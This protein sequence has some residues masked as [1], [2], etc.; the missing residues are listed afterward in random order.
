MTQGSQTWLDGDSYVGAW[1]D[2]VPSG[3]GA[4]FWNNGNAHQGNN[5]ILEEGD[6]SGRTAT[7]DGQGLHFRW[8]DG[9]AFRCKGIR[10]CFRNG[11][12]AKEN[13][14][15]RHA[16][17]KSPRGAGFVD[18]DL[19]EG[20]YRGKVSRRGRAPHGH[21]TMYFL[22]GDKYV[23]QWRAGVME[24]R[25][26]RMYSDG[27]EYQGGFSDGVPDGE[28]RLATGDLNVYE[29]SFK[30]GVPGGGGSGSGGG[31]GGAGKMTYKNGDTY[32]GEWR[33]GKRWGQGVSDGSWSEVNCVYHVPYSTFQNFANNCTVHS[34]SPV[35]TGTALRA[36][37][38]A[39]AAA[40]AL[41]PTLTGQCTVAS[42]T[43]TAGGTAAGT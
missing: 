6:S 16:R 19:E 1:E 36:S 33:D 14:T 37:G 21:G 38:A 30:G 29:G 11:L 3:W 39:P 18:L 13:G 40:G 10:I 24:G 12:M 43:W 22:N 41:S 23:G 42:G 34:L 17:R 7:R 15:F 9:A 2:G 5:V 31:S 27:D 28:G 25:G 20:W 35:T 26:R 4:S 8:G 32:Q